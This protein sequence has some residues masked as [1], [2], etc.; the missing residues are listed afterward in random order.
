MLIINQKFEN[1]DHAL[2]IQ[3][4]YVTRPVLLES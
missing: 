3:Y 1:Y 2:K 4:L